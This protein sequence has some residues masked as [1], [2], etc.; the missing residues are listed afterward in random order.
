MELALELAR[1]SMGRT[2]PNPAVGAVLV[3]DGEI[4]GRGFH[5][6]SGVRHAEIVALQEAGA[7]ARGS[8]CYVTLEPCSHRGRTGP[9][10]DALIEAGVARVIAAMEDPNPEVAGRGFDRLRVAGI[11]VNWATEYETAASRINEAF[12]H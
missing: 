9:C 11:E 4:V 8:T 12:V 3:R 7:R 10:A 2:S 6:W 5:T 1:Q